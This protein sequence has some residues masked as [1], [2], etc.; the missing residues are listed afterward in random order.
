MTKPSDF[1]MQLATEAWKTV[2]DKVDPALAMA[3]AGIIDKLK[4]EPPAFDKDDAVF[5]AH[6]NVSTSMMLPKRE[7]SLDTIPME[8]PSALVAALAVTMHN[9]PQELRDFLMQDLQ[10]EIEKD[11]ILAS[12]L[13]LLKKS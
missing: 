13:A 5:I 2:P 6:P 3:F 12:I 8:G 1:A 7:M 11:K 4:A 9:R 10:G